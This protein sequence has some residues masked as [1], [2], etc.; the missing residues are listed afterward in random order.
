MLLLTSYIIF[1]LYVYTFALFWCLSDC[2]QN[3]YINKKIEEEKI[4]LEKEVELF[5]KNIEVISSEAVEK[6]IEKMY[7]VKPDANNMKNIIHKYSESY[8]ND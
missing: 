4:K 2:I 8:N 5:N 7:Y 3:N 1:C 6:I